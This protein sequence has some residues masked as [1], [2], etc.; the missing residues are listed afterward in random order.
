[1]TRYAPDLAA[2]TYSFDG[3]RDLAVFMVCTNHF[4][5][6]FSTLKPVEVVCTNETIKR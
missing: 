3:H 2:N 4:P 1:M 5:I 6:F